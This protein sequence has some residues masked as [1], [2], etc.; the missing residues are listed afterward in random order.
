M[1]DHGIY[2]A[3]GST[4]GPSSTSEHPPGA[5][6]PKRHCPSKER[7]VRPLAFGDKTSVRFTGPTRQAMTLETWHLPQRADD[8]DCTALNAPFT[9]DHR[10]MTKAMAIMQDTAS[11]AAVALDSLRKVKEV[12]TNDFWDPRFVTDEYLMYVLA[13]DAEHSTLVAC[14]YHKDNHHKT[15]HLVLL[16]ILHHLLGLD[17]VSEATEFVCAGV[18]KRMPHNKVV[19]MDNLSGTFQPTSNQLWAAHRIL[20]RT[21]LGTLFVP[22][23]DEVTHHTYRE[24]F[25]NRSPEP[26]LLM[27]HPDANHERKEARD[28][29]RVP[30]LNQ[31]AYTSRWA[32]FADAPDDD[33]TE[34]WLETTGLKDACGGGGVGVRDACFLYHWFRHRSTEE[35]KH[36]ALWR[37]GRIQ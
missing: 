23:D 27:D 14:T 18:M 11:E 33:A 12:S 8:E 26:R 5:P 24:C 2:R 9:N 30:E 28:D 1:R 15:K 13:H 10:D 6:A 32:C 36:I 29:S 16:M 4:P 34:E 3:G 21:F 19:Y 20:S 7:T 25:L 35:V 31:G 17:A 37:S 22:V